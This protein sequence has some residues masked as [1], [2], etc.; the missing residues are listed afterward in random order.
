M[1]WWSLGLACQQ[2]VWRYTPA[3]LLPSF[4]LFGSWGRF[5]LDSWGCWE[6]FDPR[7]SGV[8]STFLLAVLQRSG[9]TAC[10][11]S[12]HAWPLYNPGTSRILDPRTEGNMW[13]LYLSFKGFKLPWSFPTHNPD[14]ISLSPSLSPS[15][16]LSVSLAH[17]LS[18]SLYDSLSLSISLLGPCG[19]HFL[20]LLGSLPTQP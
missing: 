5:P 14:S 9:L 1:E 3:G 15:V 2:Q 8:D 10:P 16:S 18:L 17:S 4:F 6:H 19:S 20:V 13:S 7:S 11:N 12:V